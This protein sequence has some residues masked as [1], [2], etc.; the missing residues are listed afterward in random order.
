[1]K[2]APQHLSLLLIAG[3]FAVGAYSNLATAADLDATFVK[4]TPTIRSEIERGRDAATEC[5]V[6]L[7]LDSHDNCLDRIERSL[8]LKNELN[9]P[10]ELGF[11]FRGLISFNNVYEVMA[12]M[13]KL[14]PRHVELAKVVQN[15]R[16]RKIGQLERTLNL[17]DD[18]VCPLFFKSAEICKQM[19]T[20]WSVPVP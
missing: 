8:R 1:M 3:I 13:N 11:N 12:K 20:R 14:Y 10:F 4:K 2:P 9:D 6:I 7:D 15:A 18:D 5:T 16:Y 17:S 19:L